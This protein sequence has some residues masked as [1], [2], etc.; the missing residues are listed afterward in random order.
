[1]LGRPRGR[2][3]DKGGVIGLKHIGR[4]EPW[5]SARLLAGGSGLCL[6][7]MEADKSEEEGSRP[8][9]GRTGRRLTGVCG[10]GQWRKQR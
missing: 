6:L 4:A 8:V 7:R 10:L 3:K 1:M 9:G 5:E 2:R